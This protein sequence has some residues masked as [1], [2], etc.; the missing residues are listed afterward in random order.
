MMFYRGFAKKFLSL[1]F[2]GNTIPLSRST[3]ERR[4]DARSH[5]PFCYWFLV[6]SRTTSCVLSSTHS[7][8]NYNHVVVALNVTSD[9]VV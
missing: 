9:N 1:L 8:T 6:R 7:V 5:V 4:L 2:V 3:S